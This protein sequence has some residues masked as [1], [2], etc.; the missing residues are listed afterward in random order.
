MSNL[1]FRLEKAS[2]KVIAKTKSEHP[3]YSPDNMSKCINAAR[4]V[5]SR[6]RLFSRI[7]AKGKTTGKSD[8]GDARRWKILR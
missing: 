6:V 4:S 8:Q 3:N 7:L 5:R 2:L 1:K